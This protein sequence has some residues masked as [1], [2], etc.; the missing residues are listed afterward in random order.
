MKRHLS[1]GRMFICALSALI[2]IGSW[3]QTPL[4]GQG[5]TG[6]I[7]GIVTDM[8][9]AAVPD[10]AVQVKDVNTGIVQSTSTNAQ[11]RY[12]VPDL[13]VGDYEVQ[14]SKMG[15]QTTVRRGITLSV[16]AQS[17]VDFSLPVGQQQQVVTVEAQ[18]SQ[19]ETTSAAVSSLTDQKQM[20]DLPLNGRNL[21]QLIQLAPG[22][23]TIQG[24]AFTSNGFGGR[25]N[26]YSIAGSRPEGQALLLDD[27]TLQGFWNRGMASVVGTSLGV[28]AIGEFQTLTNTYSAQFGGNGGVVN[29]VSKSGTNTFHG[30]A[31]EFLRN[32]AL[33]ARAFIDPGHSPPAFRRNQYGGSLGGPVRKDKAF[34]F[35]NYEGIRQLLGETKIA[36]VPG[37]NLN[38]AA[39][40]PTTTNPATRQAIIN[41]LSVFPN[42][43]SVVNG[44]PRATSVANQIAH[45]DYV[46][47]RFDYAIS[48]KDSIFVR[49]VSD[50]SSF[51]EP[52]GGGAFGGGPI[53][54][55]PELD[56]SHSNFATTEW[57]RIVSPT[58]VNVARASFSRPATNEFTDKSIGRGIVN[59]TDPLQFFGGARQD[60]IVNITGLSGIGGAL[61]LPFNT[62]QNRF[63]EGDDV[64]W[65]HGAHTLRFGGSVSRLQTNTFMPFFHGA[66]WSFTG[67]SGGPFPFL[68]G[69]PTTLIYVPLGSY[70]NRDFREIEITP[71]LQDDW[72]VSQ[73]LTLNLGLRWEFVTNPVDQHNQLNTITN[74]DTAAPPNL[75][76]H[77]QHPMA[78][79]PSW[80]N[81]DP[82]FGFAYDAFADH[83]TSIRGG[84]G[85]FR[86]VILP[87]DYSPGFWASP[88]W[89]LTVLPGSLG[90]L[91]PNLPNNGA[92][93][94]LNVGKPSSSPAWDYNTAVTPY[95]MQWNLNIQREVARN[96][97]LNIGYVGSRGVHLITGLQANPP[98]V[99]LA[100]EGPHCANPT[101]AKGFAAFAEGGPGGYLGFGT[102]GAVT[103]NPD[104]NNFLAGFPNLGTY[105][106]SSY[107]SG[108]VSLN[109]RFTSNVQVQASYTWSRC[110]DNGGYLTSLNSNT[111]G[112][113]TNP[114]NG[115]TDKAPCGWDLNH[116]A[117][118]NGLIALPFHGN[119][120]V[121][122]WQISGILSA[123]TGYPLNI[124]D[125][126][127]ETAGGTPVAIA[128]RPNLNPGCSNNPIIGSVNRWYDVTCF[129]LLRPARSATLAETLCAGRTS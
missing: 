123:T 62:T 20:R 66:Q 1:E 114:Y 17:V 48:D 44:Q 99:C 6:S 45:E 34:F 65:T 26:G 8:S 112:A 80:K 5:A 113:F 18:A 42:A 61:Q 93:G 19:V 116:V 10:T 72:K 7:L 46:L 129:S 16:G 47:A 104:R 124:T 59:G 74:F 55:W 95:V 78:T 119:Q 103:S 90:A 96:T 127:D 32:S 69:V 57:R 76:T 35:V 105:A 83:K 73:K 38:T 118:V 33:D 68:G 64:T 126:Y 79:N 86:H 23:N 58:L 11:A 91:F 3:S 63:T 102:V 9:G 56:A 2:I 100:S 106:S 84:F 15:F 121:E 97:V 70:P 28:E 88:P 49:Y 77:V 27:E 94:G 85:M 98:T 89:A 117:R 39:C 120:F 81:F 125:G 53:P 52:F 67:L 41:T 14:A 29:A 43:D 25:A 87:P 115:N 24:N 128:P 109:R 30:S 4:L 12:T 82:R 92:A 13:R 122:G 110:M 21:E 54:F 107:H 31:Y 22:V 50:K 37:C 101:Y 111:T 71:Y 40:T 60:G 36:N 75:F 108:V 51:V